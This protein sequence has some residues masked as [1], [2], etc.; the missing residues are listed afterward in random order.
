MITSAAIIHRAHTTN[1]TLHLPI[2][3]A[4]IRRMLAGL[5]LGA[6]RCGAAR[7]PAVLQDDQRGA[8]AGERWQGR[9]RPAPQRGPERQSLPG[10]DWMGRSQCCPIASQRCCCG[11]QT[12]FC[13]S[14]HQSPPHP[15]DDHKL[16]APLQTVLRELLLD[17]ADH[18]VELWEGSGSSWRLARRVHLDALLSDCP[19]YLPTRAAS[20]TVQ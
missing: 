14:A 1:R 16:V 20:P 12:E 2:K 4:P 3:L 11:M 9:S 18:A 15:S 13:C 17:A 8:H 19:T 10:A 7:G 5:L 6:W